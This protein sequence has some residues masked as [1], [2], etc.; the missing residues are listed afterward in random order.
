MGF[1]LRDDLMPDG[2]SWMVAQLKAE[3]TSRYGGRAM[4]GLSIRWNSSFHLPSHHRERGRAPR[5]CTQWLEE[6]YM[7]A[8]T[9]KFGFDVFPGENNPC[10]S[11]CRN[12]HGA[13][14]RRPEGTGSHPPLATGTWRMKLIKPRRCTA[15]KQHILCLF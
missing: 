2:M 13:F 11:L 4:E 10:E 9:G 1:S 8:E 15:P 7:V 3:V 12:A 6:V 5:N 14:K